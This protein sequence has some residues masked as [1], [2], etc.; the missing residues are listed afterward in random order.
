M[1]SSW[2]C[3]WPK[4]LKPVSSSCKSPKS[5][6]ANV[7]QIPATKC[8][9][10]AEMAS[11]SCI[12][13]ICFSARNITIAPRAPINAACGVDTTWQP[14]VIATNPARVPLI[15]R[16]VV[17]LLSGCV[18]ESR[19]AVIPPAAA[20]MIVLTMMPAMAVVKANV[21]PPLK[22]IQPIIKNS[23]PSIASGRLLP[24][25]FCTLPRMKR[26]VRGPITMTAARATQPPTLC[27]T[28]LPAK[29]VNPIASSQPG[30]SL[31]ALL[32]TQ[33]PNTG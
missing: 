26:P 7:P 5:A 30:D 2:T 32:Q 27:T 1:P 24:G 4:R 3:S 29:S 23:M 22:P 18:F 14:A 19:M 28:V 25:M 17:W 15:V 10:T 11:S 12:R 16:D 21:L 9:G 33:W 20:A 13:C 31:T 6:T 8:T